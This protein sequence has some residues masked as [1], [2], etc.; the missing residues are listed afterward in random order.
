LLV[1]LTLER[2]GNSSISVG[3]RIT[4]DETPR[5]FYADGITVLVWIDKTTGRSTPLPEPV[6]RAIGRG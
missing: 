4:S 2:A 5:R 3:F 1:D 6:R